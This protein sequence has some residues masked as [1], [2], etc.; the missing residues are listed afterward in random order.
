MAKDTSNTEMDPKAKALDLAMKQI[1]KLGP[2]EGMLGM[3]PGVDAKALKKAKMDPK[4]LKHVEAIILSMTPEERK[5]PEILNG[6][7]RARIAKGAGRPVNEINKLLEQFRGMQKMMKK[8]GMGGGMP[9]GGR[10]RRCT[11]AAITGS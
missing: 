5:K 11:T 10:M 3:L 6:S 4:R 2:L 8:M 7:R 1:E 9:G